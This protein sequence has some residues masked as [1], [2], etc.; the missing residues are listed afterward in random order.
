MSPKKE[1]LKKTKTTI[2]PSRKF[3]Y[4]KIVELVEDPHNLK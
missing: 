4:I 2:K 1:T 3:K